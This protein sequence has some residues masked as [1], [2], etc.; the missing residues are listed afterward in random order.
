MPSARSPQTMCT[1]LPVLLK[2]AT[3]S[4][5]DDSCL[6]QFSHVSAVAFLSIL[7]LIAAQRFKKAQ[8]SASACAACCRVLQ[9]GSHMKQRPA[10]LQAY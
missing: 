10:L 7:P 2:W 1:C 5:E 6:V 8:G 4:G 9:R 3:S